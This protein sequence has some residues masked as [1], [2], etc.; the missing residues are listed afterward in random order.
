MSPLNR[1]SKHRQNSLQCSRTPSR[2]Q[3]RCESSTLHVAYSMRMSMSLNHNSLNVLVVGSG[4]REHALVTAIASSPYLANL[5]VAPGSDA[6]ARTPCNKTVQCFPVAV[7]DNEKLVAL[8]LE[9]EADLVVVGPEVPLVTG[10]VDLLN[11]AGVCAFGPTAAG[12]VLEGS[13]AFTKNFMAKYDIPTAWYE[14]FDDAGEAKTFVSKK[15]VPIVIKADGLAAGKGV[16]IAESIDTAHEAID[17]ILVQK[18]FGS[19]GDTLVIEEFLDGE[20]LSFF[21]LLDGDTCLPLTSAQD[22]K[23]AHDGDQG[24][25]TGGMGAYS[26]AP[27]CDAKMSKRV[28]EEIVIPTMKGLQ[29]EGRKFVGV[30]YCGLMVSGDSIKVLE[31]NVRFGDPE[32]QVMCER[33]KTDMLEVLYHTAMGELHNVE[34][35]WKDSSAVVVVMA[36]K[37]YPR[38][39]EKGSVIRNLEAAEREGARIYHAGTKLVGEEFVANGGRVLGVTATGGT[40]LDAQQKA[41]RSVSKI[42]WPEGFWRSD[43]GW[44][45]VQREKAQE[46]TNTSKV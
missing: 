8:A 17:N 2:K 15:G 1:V 5:L 28:M 40:V 31:Y 35:K 45:A 25:N 46:I 22:H 18:Q 9:R 27:F 7:E 11:R 29:S 39:Y 20:E 24:P 6:I 10:L 36:T 34:I 38:G 42:E 16:I 4:G 21:A 33:M 43:I 37:G 19:A 12:A 30:L 44:R 32:C 23:K 41:Y 3:Q 26:P 13:K 14:T